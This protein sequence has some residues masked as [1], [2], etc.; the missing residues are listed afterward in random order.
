M[1]KIVIIGTN[2]FIGTNFRKFSENQQITEVSIRETNPKDIDFKN[3]D[4]VLHLAAIVHQSKRINKQE[5]FHINRDLPVSIAEHARQAGVKQFIFLST[6]KVYGKF[7]P[8][9]DPWTEDSACYPYDDYGR[10]KYSAEI[11]L[12]KMEDENFAVSIIR[13]PIVY[14][15]D[16]KANML[17]LIHLVEKCHLLPF[18]KVNNNR[19]YTFIKNLVGFIDRIIEIRASGTFIAM[20]DF[21]LTTTILVKHLARFL[22][23]K[24]ILLKIPDIF[25]R[26]A[27]SLKVPAVDQLYGSFFLNNTKTKELLNYK[28]PFSTEYGIE[29]MI[30]NYLENKN[31]EKK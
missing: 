7:I 30:S 26:F 21:G 15:P 9:S 4:V 8:G 29:K 23:R 6:V 17:K 19:H 5:Y 28:S 11:A 31:T 22:H 27:V 3:V 2:S 12:K 18:D 25:T 14:G 13:T 16:V 20:D 24:V 10:S 1:K